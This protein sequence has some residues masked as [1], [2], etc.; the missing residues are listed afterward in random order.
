[1]PFQ[2]KSFLY[3]VQVLLQRLALVV[4]LVAALGLTALTIM[5]ALG[6]APW[7]EFTVHLGD[8]PY[9]GAGRVAQIAVTA[10]AVLLCVYLPAN[11]R[12]LRLETSHRRFEIGMQDVARA[13]AAAHAA[14]RQDLFQLSSEFDAVRERLANLR[15]DLRGLLPEL[16]RED[17]VDPDGKVMVLSKKAAE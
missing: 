2:L 14:D 17:I 3:L 5:A 12:M 7:L 13:H 9:H 8:T 15:D 11:W 6:L 16:G 10:L 4:F 1:M